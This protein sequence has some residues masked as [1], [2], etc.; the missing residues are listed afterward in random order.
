LRSVGGMFNR[1]FERCISAAAASAVIGI[2]ALIDP[3]VRTTMTE[4]LTQ[5]SVTQ[6]A[7]TAAASPHWLR[8]MYL[9]LSE[10]PLYG[11]LTLFVG[12][13]GGLTVLMLRA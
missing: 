7:V 6:M 10:N 11:P 3:R 5:A 9:A 4:C 2:L 8:A 12:I 1:W 13:A